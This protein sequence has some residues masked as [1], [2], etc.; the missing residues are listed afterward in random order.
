MKKLYSKILTP[1]AVALVAV[2][3]LTS[4]TQ[5]AVIGGINLNNT[6]T[7]GCNLSVSGSCGVGAS[8]QPITFSI[9]G[10]NG[11]TTSLNGSTV[12]ATGTGNFSSTVTIPTSV[13]PGADTLVANC[14]TGDTLQ[15]SVSLA[16][17]I[18][19]SGLFIVTPANGNVMVG[20]TVGVNGVCNATSGNVTFSLVQNGV[21]TNLSSNFAPIS[22][23]GTFSANVNIPA[24][25]AA[26]NATLVANCGNGTTVGAQLA[27]SAN[28][29]PPIPG[30][31][32]IT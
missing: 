28:P 30:I 26:G 8:G 27:L 29:V 3:G 20:G 12:G 25:A 4:L 17:L 13:S 32:S 19:N 2:L 23:S 14:N 24:G 11:V 31:T 21:S 5:A 9:I 6:A 7:L 18:S 1:L 16:P 22:G 15:T 10:S